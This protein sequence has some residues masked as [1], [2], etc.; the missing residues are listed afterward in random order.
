MAVVAAASLASGGRALYQ[1]LSLAFTW[2]GASVFPPTVQRQLETLRS[3]IP[4]GSH[5]LLVAPF[6]ANGPWYSRLF[7]RG[8]YPGVVVIVRY[9]PPPDAAA[10]R[11]LRRQYDLRYAVSMGDPPTDPGFVAHDDLGPLPGIPDRVWFGELA[12]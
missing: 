2:A 6:G 1:D 8:L 9:L 12:P 3:R 7:Q 11:R 5:V 4:R 10:L